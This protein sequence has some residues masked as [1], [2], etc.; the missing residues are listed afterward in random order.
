M[1]YMQKLMH[2]LDAHYPRWFIEL[3]TQSEL[4]AFIAQCERGAYA[5]RTVENARYELRGRVATRIE[6]AAR[7]HARRAKRL[8]A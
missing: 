8:A 5:P 4:A 1:T 7:R 6:I 2:G 3:A